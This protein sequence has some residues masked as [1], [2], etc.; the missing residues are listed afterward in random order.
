MYVGNEDENCK[1]FLETERGQP[2]VQ[3]FRAIR[4]PHILNDV[5]S[6]HTLESDRIIPESESD[7]MAAFPFQ[8]CGRK[9]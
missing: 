9:A 3:V 7:T 1:Y 4:I 6:V 5:V 8:I 2:Y